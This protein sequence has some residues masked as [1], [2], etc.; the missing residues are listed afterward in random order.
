MK[1]LQRVVSKSHHALSVHPIEDNDEIVIW[2][3]PEGKKR[4]VLELMEQALIEYHKPLYNDKH[5]DLSK[6]RNEAKPF[7]LVARALSKAGE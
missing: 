1:G 5:K 2:F 7:L 4:A 3:P 6:P